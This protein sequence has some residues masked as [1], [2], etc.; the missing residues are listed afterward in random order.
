MSDFRPLPNVTLPSTDTS[1]TPVAPAP[2]PSNIQAAKP[3][4]LNSNVAK[5]SQELYLAGVKST[6]TADERNLI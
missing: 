6:L 1:A 3:L 2:T 5:V 4:A